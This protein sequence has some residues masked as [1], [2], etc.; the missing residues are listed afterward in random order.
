M[1]RPAVHCVWEHDQ[2][3][4]LQQDAQPVYAK[5]GGAISV[6]QVAKRYQGAKLALMTERRRTRLALASPELMLEREVTLTLWESVYRVTT[7]FFHI[8]M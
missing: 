3:K 5:L 7:V 2:H 4:E 8:S 1:H 6:P